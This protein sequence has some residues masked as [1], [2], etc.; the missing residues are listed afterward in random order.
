MFVW[1]EFCEWNI[2]NFLNQWSCMGKNTGMEFLLEIIH[3]GRW[4]AGNFKW[5]FS[6]VSTS[7][8]PWTSISVKAY[9]ASCSNITS[10]SLATFSVGKWEIEKHMKVCGKLK[11]NYFVKIIFAVI[12]KLQNITQIEYSASGSTLL[13]SQWTRDIKQ[14]SK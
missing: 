10:H 6:V 13:I 3:L 8:L 5:W 7:K 9:R 11:K 2:E 12:S 4:I 14:L 1:L